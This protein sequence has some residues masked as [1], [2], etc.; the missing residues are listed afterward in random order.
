MTRRCTVTCCGAT[1]PTDEPTAIT[2]AAASRSPCTAWRRRVDGGSGRSFRGCFG[3]ASPSPIL[4]PF[5]HCAF[6]D[7]DPDCYSFCFCVVSFYSFYF[8]QP[9]L[10]PT[11]AQHG[12]P[13]RRR[14]LPP[15]RHRGCRDTRIRVG[16]RSAFDMKCPV[17]HI[18]SH[19]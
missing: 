14:P 3:T 10:A 19:D 13:R 5:F 12:Q 18:T 9:P 15:P 17:L 16:S 8:R 7:A 2:A 1:Q 11:R 6:T 4:G